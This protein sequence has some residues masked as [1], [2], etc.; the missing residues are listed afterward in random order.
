VVLAE[1][2]P[3]RMRYSMGRLKNKVALIS[4]G[5]RGMGAAEARLFIARVIVGDVLDDE[6][7]ALAEELNANADARAVAAVHLDVSCAGDWCTA[8]EACE[9]EFA[10][11]ITPESRVEG[12]SKTPPKKIGKQSSM[13]TRRVYGWG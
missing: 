8:V 9:H 4:D 2:A 5:A 10:W 7:K 12:A 6:A 1:N 11:S 13:S 3:A